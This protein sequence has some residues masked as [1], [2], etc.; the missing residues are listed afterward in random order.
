[1]GLTN[2]TRSA[3]IQSISYKLFTNYL[4]HQINQLNLGSSYGGC[5]TQQRKL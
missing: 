5:N 3:K 2:P 4:N 1:M